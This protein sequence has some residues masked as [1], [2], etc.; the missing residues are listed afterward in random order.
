MPPLYQAIVGY[1]NKFTPEMTNHQEWWGLQLEFETTH[2]VVDFRHGRHISP[3]VE[4]QLSDLLLCPV[5]HMNWR[6]PFYSWP[7]NDSQEMNEQH[8]FQSMA[9]LCVIGINQT[10]GL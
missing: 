3:K 2:V 5:E 6:Q 7:N 10:L 4:L 9:M 8:S 1:P